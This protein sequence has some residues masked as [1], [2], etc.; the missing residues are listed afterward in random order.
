MFTIKK[1]K[2]DSPGTTE[3]K[4]P[5]DEKLLSL[6]AR[7]T[8][9][10]RLQIE[11]TILEDEVAFLKTRIDEKREEIAEKSKLIDDMAIFFSD[12][13][14]PK[15]LSENEQKTLESLREL[16]NLFLDKH[17]I[18]NVFGYLDRRSEKF[19][20][21]IF[22]KNRY[23]D[24]TIEG[25]D[26]I[27]LLQMKDGIH[28]SID[29]ITTIGPRTIMAHDVVRLPRDNIQLAINELKQR[30]DLTPESC[31]SRERNASYFRK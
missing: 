20:F 30:M 10:Q 16:F 2:T 27:R 9:L 4:T 22:P 17:N 15:S 26:A 13:S 8:E 23:V 14:L 6:E 7:Q 29:L 21:I 3:T 12:V 31:A 11:V 28:S 25:S 19:A 5:E 18:Q 24:Q 1:R